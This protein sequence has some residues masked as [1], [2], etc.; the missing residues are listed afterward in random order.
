MALAILRARM[1]V[2]VES[3]PL[4]ENLIHTHCGNCVSI[5]A[6]NSHL[7]NVIDNNPLYKTHSHLPPY[8]RKTNVSFCM[9]RVRMRTELQRQLV[10]AR[11]NVH[12]LPNYPSNESSIDVFLSHVHDIS[13]MVIAFT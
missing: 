13:D 5:S 3:F 4:S 6:N 11:I 10:Q 9:P 7:L 2:A 12:Y 1:T 8:L